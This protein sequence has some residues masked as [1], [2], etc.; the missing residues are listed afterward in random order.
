VARVRVALVGCGDVSR[1]YARRIVETDGLDLAGATDLVEGRAA[2]L[3]AGHGGVEYPSLEALLADGAVDTVV[4]LTAPVAHA[5]VTAASLEAGK[6]VHTEKPVALRHAEAVE[7][8]ELAARRGVRLSCSPATLLGEAQ[9]TAWKLVREGGLGTVRAVYAEANWG[10]SSPG[11]RR[12]R[13]ST[14]SARSSTSAS[15]R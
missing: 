3:V 4:N 13:P 11:I 6:H 15:T 1:R 9:Q 5:A 8:A 10:G 7:L 2:A 12:R 14:P